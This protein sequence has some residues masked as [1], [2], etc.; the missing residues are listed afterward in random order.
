MLPVRPDLRCVREVVAK[1]EVS[2]AGKTDLQF[3]CLAGAVLTRKRGA[4]VGA[5]SFIRTWTWLNASS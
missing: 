5:V 3:R 1:S 4:L 2:I